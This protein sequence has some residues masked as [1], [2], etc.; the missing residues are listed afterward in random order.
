M[1]TIDKFMLFQLILELCTKKTLN[2]LNFLKRKYGHHRIVRNNQCSLPFSVT[3]AVYYS[4]FR[5]FNKDLG[6]CQRIMT[7][8]QESCIQ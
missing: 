7:N 2:F 5:L 1:E 4:I 6:I 3:I 8:Y